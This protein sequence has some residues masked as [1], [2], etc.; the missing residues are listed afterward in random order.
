MSDGGTR[1]FTPSARQCRCALIKS[2]SLMTWG[3]Y[4][5]YLEC[6]ASLIIHAYSYQHQ[7]SSRIVSEPH[8]F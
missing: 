8:Y 2:C 1:L 7:G 3:V 6:I 5:L 4:L